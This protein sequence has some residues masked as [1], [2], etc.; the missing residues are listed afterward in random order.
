MDLSVSISSSICR[1]SCNRVLDLRKSSS[2]ISRMAHQLRG[3]LRQAAEQFL[4]AGFGQHASLGDA[5]EVVRG[6]YAGAFR[7]VASVARQQLQPARLH[8]LLYSDAGRLISVGKRGAEREASCETRTAS[9][10]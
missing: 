1:D 5:A 10:P 3:A 2:S 4:H 9:I 6:G 8:S 7:H